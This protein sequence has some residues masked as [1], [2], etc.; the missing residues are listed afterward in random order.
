VTW[1]CEH[2]GLN[3]RSTCLSEVT[4]TFNMFCEAS[5]EFSLIQAAALD[6]L[7]RLKGSR[8]SVNDES[9]GWPSTSRLIVN[10]GKI[11]ELIHKDH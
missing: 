10:A 2:I 5:T 11:Q 4:E 3:T 1:R 8:V 9:L 6:W 7:S